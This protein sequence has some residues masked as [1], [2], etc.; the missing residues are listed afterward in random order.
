MTT[1]E[2]RLTAPDGKIG[3]VVSR[4]NELITERL[5]EGAVTA[6]KRHGG[7]ESQLEIAR[8]PGAF[9]MPLVA[10]KMAQS[11]K[12]RAIVCLGCVIRGATD[13]YDYVCGP[14]ASGI[15]N[16]G[17]ASGIPIIFGVLTTDNLEQ[18]FERAGSK[19]GNKGAEAMLAALE[20]VDVLA[21][22]SG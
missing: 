4:F 2:G 12:F 15:M 10:Q 18:A 7:D 11:G 22:L 20:T 13:H 17:L 1:Y 3:I 8:V 9:E 21:Q 19:A 6:L 16:A 14:T 5:L